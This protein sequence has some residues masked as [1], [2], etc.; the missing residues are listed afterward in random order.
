M[1]TPEMLWFDLC[2]LPLV[3]LGA[4][5]GRRVFHIIP[6]RIFDPLVLLLA[7]VAALRMVVM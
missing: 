1:V 5:V 3:V 6:Q 4:L 2:V 7:G